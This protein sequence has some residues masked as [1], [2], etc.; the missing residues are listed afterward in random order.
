[1][2]E[3]L[4]GITPGSADDYSLAT[5]ASVEDEP[6]HWLWYPYIPFGMITVVQGYPGSGKSSFL[7]DI[8]AR[9]TRGAPLP[10]GS[11]PGNPVSAVYQCTEA[12]SQGVIKTMLDNSGADL[13][14]VSF[15]RGSFLTVNDPRIQ[16]AVRES[17]SKILIIDPI[18][19]FFEAAM[20][21]AQHVRKELSAIG[22]FAAETGCAVILIGHFTKKETGEAQY[23]GM[24]SADIAAIARSIIHVRRAGKDSPLRYIQH[25][26]CSIAPE[27]DPCVF[28]L[29]GL[30]KVHWIGRP[31]E[32]EMVC[33]ER[34][35]GNSQTPRLIE[36]MSALSDI[37]GAGD[38]EAV[39][40]MA[41]M[42]EKGFSDIT[43]RRAKR[44]L[45]IQSFRQSEK[46]WL[47]RLPS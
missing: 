38:L 8:V 46:G 36:A 3:N 7:L 33:L 21:N 40:V 10:D 5:Y 17:D 13:T 29:T 1:M 30:G 31:N 28:E 44:G 9:A 39:E 12:G 24:G 35:A 45:D 27:G 2:K 23:Q 26:K 4:N 19:N 6:V 41:K 37:L 14:R 43:I 32:D 34:K 42:K 47:W 15:I 18:Q 25:M 22:D 16:R 11:D 20:S